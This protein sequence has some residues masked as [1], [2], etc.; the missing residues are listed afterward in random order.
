MADMNSTGFPSIAIPESKKDEAWHKNFV[1]TITNRGIVSGYA[2][3][4]ALANECVNYYLGLDGGASEFEFL[5]KAEDGEV[6]PAR[7]MDFNKINVKINLLLGELLEKSYDISVKAINKDARARR[8]DEKERLRTEMRFTP[9]ADMLE[10]QVGLPLRSGEGFTPSSEEELDVYME[11]DFKDICEIVMEGALKFLNQAHYWDYERMACF[12]D[13]LITGMAFC[14]NE[15]VEGLPTFK[16]IDPRYMVWDQN[17][18]DDFLS[19]STFF[20]EICYMS[21]KDIVARYNISKK[22]LDEAFK[23][24]QSYLM[25][26]TYFTYAANDYGFIDKRSSVRIFRNEGGELRVLVVRAY[27]QDYKTISYKESK[28]KYGNDHYKRVNE[29]S[30]GAE[31]NKKTVSFWR[32]G[33]LIAGKYL[34][35]WGPMEN[36]VRSADDM[37]PTKPPYVCL[38]P[39]YMNGVAVSK[40]AQLKSLQKLKNI[41]LYNVQLAMARAGAKGFFYDVA[42]LP[43]DWDINKA[44]KYL[45]IAGIAFIDSTAGGNATSFN[46]F[47]E[48]D[49]TLSG[50]VTQFIQISQYL[51]QEMDAISGVNEARQGLVKNASQAVGVTQSALVQSSISTAVYFKLFSH[52]FTKILNY[53]AGL[54]KIAWAGKERFAPIIG[55]IGVNF[56]QHNVDID[57]QDYGVFVKEVPPLLAE[58]QLF[59]QF[60]M[61]ALQAGQLRFVD[62][63]KLSMESDIKAGVRQLERDLREQEQ[64]MMA[65]QVAMEQA[66]QQQMAAQA[67][68]NVESDKI[69]ADIAK[70]K[71]AADLTKILTQG[72]LDTLQGVLGAKQN[73]AQS[74]VEFAQDMAM[75][76]LDMKI[77]QQKADADAKKARDKKINQKQD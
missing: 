60:I 35:D 11:K 74:Q 21:V 14:K 67:Q 16:R 34:K 44:M 12:R 18:T 6:L 37:A 49:Q 46:Q 63:V 73:M 53:Q 33:T 19:D 13:L 52:F 54:V 26:D 69:K 38:I 48:F 17:A 1:Q 68:A 32:Q 24:Y 5:Q 40:V 30:E 29:E 65:Q 43:P 42:Q 77:A 61:G 31:V 7:W 9:I 8:L 57:L 23:A 10:E 36:Q 25:N 71:G 50:S 55:D 4:Y 41:A 28:D 70:Q 62:A 15:I 72:R 76:Q 20:G 27:W 59:Q 3:R 2:E 47:K 45:K 51:D 39:H 75:K 56:L 66:K 64:R 58:R 22:E